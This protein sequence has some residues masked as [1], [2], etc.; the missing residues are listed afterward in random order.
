MKSN[1]NFWANKDV[2][3]PKMGTD[4]VPVGDDKVLIHRSTLNKIDKLAEKAISEITS[5]LAELLKLQ[6]E[7]PEVNFKYPIKCLYE[8]LEILEGKRE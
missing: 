3:P 5:C 8:A 6:E 2:K 7:D 1:P 4:K